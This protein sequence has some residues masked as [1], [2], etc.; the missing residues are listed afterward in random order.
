MTTDF[1]IPPLDLA[2]P[3]PPAP[4]RK[5][6]RGPIPAE[7]PIEK[8]LA[9]ID[10]R[11]QWPLD[12]SPMASTP[13]TLAAGDYSV[14]GL[15]NFV[16]VERKS[17]S[18]FVACCGTE[19][20]RFEACIQRLLG[21]P[22]RAIVVEATRP[23]LERGEWRSEITAPAVVG[24]YLGWIAAGVPIVLSGSHSQAARDVAAILAIAARRRWREARELVIGAE[25]IADDSHAL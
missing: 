11:E 17:L 6:V 4:R 9:V 20:E 7:L 15:E 16:A 2:E 10:T 13:G 24:S 23:D 18:D 1:E 19:R 14:Y 3:K 21:Y 25:R 12:L 22:C 5:S 8:I